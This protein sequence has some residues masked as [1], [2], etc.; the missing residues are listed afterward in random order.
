M[1]PDIGYDLFAA[2]DQNL[3][4]RVHC[5]QVVQKEGYALQMVQVG[6]SKEYVSYAALRDFFQRERNGSRIEHKEIVNEKSRGIESRGFRTC[7][8]ENADFHRYLHGGKIMF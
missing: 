6:M 8:S 4:V 1:P 3:A 7:R 2:K 5:V